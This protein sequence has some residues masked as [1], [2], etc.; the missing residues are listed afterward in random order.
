MVRTGG[1]VT[2]GR[3]A[4]SVSGSTRPGRRRARLLRSPWPSRAATCKIPSRL[5]RRQR[6]AIG[7]GCTPRRCGM[8]LG[9]DPS[10]PL[11]GGVLRRQLRRITEVRMLLLNVTG[12]VEC[13]RRFVRPPLVSSPLVSAAFMGPALM[14]TVSRN[15]AVLVVVSMPGGLGVFEFDR[16]GGKPLTRLGLVRWT[17]SIRLVSSRSARVPPTFGHSCAPSRYLSTP[18]GCPGRFCDSITVVSARR[19][20]PAESPR[21]LPDRQPIVASC[22]ALRVPEASGSHQP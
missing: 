3:P 20:S 16:A 11:A 13:S 2:T 18:C 4:R 1:I 19:A 7:V 17:W 22:H 14:D 15:A 6:G 5:F 10:G 9:C 12:L 21:R 8:G